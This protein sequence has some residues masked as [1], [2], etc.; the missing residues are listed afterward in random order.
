MRVFAIRPIPYG[1]QIIMNY[2]VPGVDYVTPT[3]DREDPLAHRHIALQRGPVMLAQDEQLGYSVDD[4]IDVL[5]NEDGTVDAKFPDQAKAPY[6][7]IL[8]MQIPLRNGTMQTVT[9][10]GSAGKLWRED[11]KM[12]VWMLTE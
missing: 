9:D 5:V 6:P 10:Y 11:L 7:N 1:T 4:P 8:E 12:A 2:K 3:F